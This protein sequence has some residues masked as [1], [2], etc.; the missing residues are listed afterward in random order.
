MVGVDN[1]DGG[2]ELPATPLGGVVD[3][4]IV[5]RK[6]LHFPAPAEPDFKAAKLGLPILTLEGTF[7]TPGIKLYGGI[8]PQE[9]YVYPYNFN[10]ADFTAEG[11]KWAA[12]TLRY[13]LFDNTSAA[14][15]YTAQIGWVA[16]I[17]FTPPSIS[18]LRLVFQT[19]ADG[20]FDP[21][22]SLA[23]TAQLGYAGKY[24]LGSHSAQT[25][26]VVFGTVLTQAEPVDDM[27]IHRSPKR[28][29]G[30]FLS[31]T[32]DDVTLSA[33][34]GA[35]ESDKK[36]PGG[37]AEILSLNAMNLG[38]QFPIGSGRAVLAGGYSY[39]RSEQGE[40]RFGELTA[41]SNSEHGFEPVT[42]HYALI[43]GLVL[44]GGGIFLVSP[45]TDDVQMLYLAVSWNGTGT[46]TF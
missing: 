30:F 3:R 20:G 5:Y 37:S 27:G 34:F 28:G 16:G 11:K 9:D 33:G 18:G 7:K 36:W 35:Q 15:L 12:S 17:E 42:V 41:T 38:Y 29:L 32:F 1:Q 26:A 31:Q 25:S 2:G 45:E 21:D 19:A 13:N 40:F 22:G 10:G 44:S 23:T 14:N 46:F 24:S 39:V 4:W 8:S 6:R 43:P